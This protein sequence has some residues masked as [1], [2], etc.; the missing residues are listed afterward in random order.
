MF[1]NL[2]SKVVNEF[3]ALSFSSLLNSTSTL[4]FSNPVAM[5]FGSTLVFSLGNPVAV[6]FSSLLAA[7]LNSRLAVLYS[8][9]KGGEYRSEASDF[10]FLL[11]LAREDDKTISISGSVI[12]KTPTPTPTPGLLPFAFLFAQFTSSVQLI[13]REDDKTF[14]ISGSIVKATPKVFK[15]LFAD[16]PVAALIFS[17]DNLVLMPSGGLRSMTFRTLGETLYDQ[18]ICSIIC[19]RPPSSDFGSSLS[20]DRLTTIFIPDTNQP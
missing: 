12:E 8:Q 4:L 9:S 1:P 2:P 19:I 7:T 3:F 6:L 20:W 17:R 15:A 5:L 18:V 14:S 11:C 16:E 10:T 13:A